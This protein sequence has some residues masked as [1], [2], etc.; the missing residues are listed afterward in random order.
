MKNRSENPDEVRE[1]DYRYKGPAPTTKEAAIVML[2]DSI[3]AAVRSIQAPNKEKIE[4]M[5]DNIIKGRLEEEQ[6]SNSELTF[7][8]IKDMR[9][10]F[11]KVLSG[12]YHERIEYPKEKTI[13]QG[14]E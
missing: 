8:D 7:K 2:A 14:K 10:A 4:A 6:L 11:L 3:E 5:V 9:E 13:E 1:E 12:I